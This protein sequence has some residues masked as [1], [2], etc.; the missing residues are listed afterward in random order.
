MARGWLE[1]E[2][3]RLIKCYPS[4]VS[5][6]TRGPASLLPAPSPALLHTLLPRPAFSFS[7]SHFWGAGSSR[8]GGAEA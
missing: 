5:F 8:K 6:P 7:L 3:V 1:E 2:G 4:P